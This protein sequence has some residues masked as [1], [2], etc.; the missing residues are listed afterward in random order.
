MHRTFKRVNSQVTEQLADLSSVELY[1]VTVNLCLDQAER[2]QPNSHKHKKL[3]HPIPMAVL[4]K[5][6]FFCGA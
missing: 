4:Q 2:K 1:I 3:T 6:S 5:F